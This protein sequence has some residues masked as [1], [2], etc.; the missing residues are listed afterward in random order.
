M[1]IMYVL[2]ACVGELIHIA[3]VSVPHFEA[4]K[5][6]FE[7]LCALVRSRKKK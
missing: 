6:F 3:L 4:W 7:W 2:L 5:Y 1:G